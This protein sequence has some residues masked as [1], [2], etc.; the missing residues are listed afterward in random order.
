VDFAVFK[1]M[2]HEGVYMWPFSS[3]SLQAPVGGGCPKEEDDQF[4][5]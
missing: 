4:G 2:F 3:L 5:L 1:T